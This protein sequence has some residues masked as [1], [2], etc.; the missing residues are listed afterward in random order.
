VSVLFSL[1]VT[2]A[3]GHTAVYAAL[4]G[5]LVGSSSMPS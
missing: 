2:F 1:W 3:A 4:L 5:L